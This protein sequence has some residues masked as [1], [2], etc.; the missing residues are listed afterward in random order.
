[1]GLSTLHQK[2]LLPIHPV[3][4]EPI[5]TIL[6]CRNSLVRAGIR[7]ILDGTR[8]VVAKELDD[9]STLPATSDASPVLYI[10]DDSHS[11]DALAKMVGELRAKCQPFKPA[12]RRTGRHTSGLG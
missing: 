7:H 11:A 6:S 4:P 8:Y 5:L 1:M 12:H 2:Q 10:L 9:S 3:L